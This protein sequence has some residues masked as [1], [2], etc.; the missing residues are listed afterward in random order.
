VSRNRVDEFDAALD[1][2][3]RDQADRIRFKSTG[4]LPPHSFVE[5]AGSG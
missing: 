4:P 1:E 2:I 5:L 3:A